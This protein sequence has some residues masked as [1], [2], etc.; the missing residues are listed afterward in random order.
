M[1]YDKIMPPDRKNTL[2]SS[3]KVP[4][5]FCSILIKFITARQ[6]SIEVPNIKF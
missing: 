3:C 1:L 6:I 5:I 2:T 4:D